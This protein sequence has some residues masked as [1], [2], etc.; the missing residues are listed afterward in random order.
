MFAP[1]CQNR[2][3]TANL[4]GFSRSAAVCH[5]TNVL[6][7]FI[8]LAH[9]SRRALVD[10]PLWQGGNVITA[11]DPVRLGRPRDWSTASWEPLMLGSIKIN[12]LFM[13]YWYWL[14]RLIWELWMKRIYRGYRWS[15]K[16][17]KPVIYIVLLNG[18][19]LIMSSKLSI[20]LTSYW[21]VTSWQLHNKVNRRSESVQ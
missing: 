17:V 10:G 5:W 2:P 16:N 14:I 7:L 13:K 8:R 11:P 3:L 15:Q 9:L 1:S 21:G 6:M 18:D 19:S 12:H 4:E 20:S